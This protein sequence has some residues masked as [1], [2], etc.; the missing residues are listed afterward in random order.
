MNS[1]PKHL[2]VL[3]QDW[4][5]YCRRQRNF[6][7]LG[8]CGCG[9]WMFECWMS[10][11]R[12]VSVFGSH[13]YKRIGQYLSLFDMYLER[14]GYML[15]TC[16][17]ELIKKSHFLVPGRDFLAKPPGPKIQPDWKLQFETLNETMGSVVFTWGLFE[18]ALGS[19]PITVLYLSVSHSW[20]KKK[21]YVKK[22]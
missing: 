20:I 3:S 15:H 4:L 1:P 8:A 9:S 12:G 11:Q 13:S 5:L 17:H 18:V 22:I 2:Q 16:I 6:S 10:R 7:Y 14:V 21:K 19:R